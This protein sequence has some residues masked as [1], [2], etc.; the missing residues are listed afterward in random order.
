MSYGFTDNEEL[1][2]YRTYLSVTENQQSD[3]PQSHNSLSYLCQN[4]KYKPNEAKRFRFTP[5][6]V[7]Q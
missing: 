3:N 1:K 7:Y 5:E 2:L 4:F 6:Q